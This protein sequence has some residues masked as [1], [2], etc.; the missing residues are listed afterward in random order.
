MVKN[1]QIVVKKANEFV[2]HKGDEV[3]FVYFVFLGEVD[4]LGPEPGDPVKRVGPCLNF[5][6]TERYG[7]SRKSSAV[8]HSYVILGALD[9]SGF[10]QTRLEHKTMEDA[11][12]FAVAKQTPPF[13]A[14]QDKELKDI[15]P[16]IFQ[17]RAPA[18]LPVC[19]NSRELGKHVVLFEIWG[20][21]VSNKYILSVLIDI[22]GVFF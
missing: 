5:G 16:Y 13:S 1:L 14:L 15:F 10:D 21:V 22:C 12:V 3:R 8:A 19:G 18:R 17:L 9:R 2:F 6:E 11:R 7:A 4:I 20:E